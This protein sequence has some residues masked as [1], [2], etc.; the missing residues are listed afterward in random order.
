MSR[1]IYIVYKQAEY[2]RVARKLLQLWKPLTKRWT[3]AGMTCEKYEETYTASVTNSNGVK[4]WRVA[5][6]NKVWLADENGKMQ[7]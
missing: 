5:N 4:A 7:M 2:Y 1:N 3:A 6:G